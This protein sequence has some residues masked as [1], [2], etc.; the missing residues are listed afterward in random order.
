VAD[1]RVRSRGLSGGWCVSLVGEWRVGGW[2]TRAASSDVPFVAQRL[3]LARPGERIHRSAVR[4]GLGA[5][6]LGKRVMSVAV[7]T[8]VSATSLDI[9]IH[10]RTYSLS[11]KHVT[12]MLLPA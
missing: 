11:G 1:V 6:A 3:G 12:S 10:S 2:A 7:T 5:A 9:F 8:V 4:F